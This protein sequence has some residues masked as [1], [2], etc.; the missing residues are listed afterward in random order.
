MFFE[1]ALCAAEFAPPVFE[2][3]CGRDV[4]VSQAIAVLYCA[5]SWIPNAV[6]AVEPRE[7]IDLI[8]F[9]GEELWVRGPQTPKMS[10]SSTAR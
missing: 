5:C 1:E 2:S 9:E 4:A 3:L 8:C 7:A 10:G 6:L